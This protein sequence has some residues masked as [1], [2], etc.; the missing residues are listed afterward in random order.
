MIANIRHSSSQPKWGTPLEVIEVVHAVLAP[1]DGAATAVT[2]DPYSEDEYNAHMLATFILDGTKGRDGYRDRW[3]PIEQCPRADHILAGYP[4]AAAHDGQR[5]HMATA[6]VNP[7][8]SD[9]GSSVKNAW[10]LL[11]AYHR[12]GW[13]GGGAVWIAFN[14]NQLQTL[15][16]ISPRHPLSPEFEGLRC[17]PDHRLPFTRH[18]SMP[19]HKPDK[20]G[21]LVEID[22][23][24]SHPC[25]FVLLPSHSE[26]LAAEQ[27]RIF[28]ECAGKLGA[29]F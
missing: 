27:R 29:V 15:Q 10:V 9:D 19:T 13:L 11:D 3:L 1:Y 26:V 18:S 22:D 28:E 14:L 21:K 7:P 24:P 6:A 16:G 23:A 20:K 12:L 17:V 5:P 8:G 25:F 4:V 2:V